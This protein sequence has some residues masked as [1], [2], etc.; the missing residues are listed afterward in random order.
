[1]YGGKS[2]PT[3]KSK[4]RGRD[5]AAER[6]D[7]EVVGLLKGLGHGQGG[8]GDSGGAVRVVAG[9]GGSPGGRRSVW[10]ATSFVRTVRGRPS[11]LSTPAPGIISVT[12]RPESTATTSAERGWMESEAMLQPVCSSSLFAPRSSS[13][14]HYA[15]PGLVVLRSTGRPVRMGL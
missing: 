4:I 3:I 8:D 10:L 2:L 1:M 11:A 5:G 7:E 6:D 14:Q 9:R 15:P 13:G 12:T